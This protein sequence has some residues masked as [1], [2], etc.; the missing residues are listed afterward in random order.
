MDINKATKE[1][2]ENAFQVDGTRAEYLVDYRSRSG[3]FKSWDEVKQVPGFEHKMVEN[4]RRA[5]LTIGSE[6]NGQTAR[7][8]SETQESRSTSAGTK[9]S[10]SNLDINSASAEQL[11]SVFEMDG[12]RARYLIQ[13]RDRLGGF[14]SW[15]QVK[16]EAPSFDDGMIR[17]LQ[18]AGATIGKAK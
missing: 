7:E 5:G 13:T 9:S 11:E 1:Q 10:R 17:N 6:G 15:D 8:R 14:E 18:Q 3:G 16:R 4:L 12:E 2:L